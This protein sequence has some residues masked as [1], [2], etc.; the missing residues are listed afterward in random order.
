MWIAGSAIVTDRHAIAGISIVG[1]V[2]GSVNE[3]ILLETKSIA[4]A[5]IL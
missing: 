1:T 2:C 4:T 5:G 3:N